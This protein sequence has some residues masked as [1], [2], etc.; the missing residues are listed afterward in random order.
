MRAL[1]QGAIAGYG[2]AIPVGPIAVLIVERGLR[3]GLRSSFPAG[4]GAAT[5]DL[6]YAT[7]AVLLGA[8]ATEALAP[9]AT[10]LRLLAAVG[11]VLFAIHGLWASR[12]ARTVETV[13]AGT[14]E[15]DDASASRTFATVFGLT[16]LNPVTVTYF[17]ALVVGGTL[18]GTDPRSRALFVVGAFAASLSWQTML[19]VTGAIGRRRLPVRAR[20]IT[21]IVGNLVI[22]ALALRMLIG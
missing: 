1:V 2:I 9:V 16:L 18:I 17:A 14:R 21:G 12:P 13:P 22:L 15:A 3:G 19:A 8:V 5:A 7:V 11:L 10:P 6:A 20:T 4:L